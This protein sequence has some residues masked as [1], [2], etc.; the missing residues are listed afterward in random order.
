MNGKKKKQVPFQESLTIRSE[1]TEACSRVRDRRTEEAQQRPPHRRTGVV[2]A[3]QDFRI[4][5]PSRWTRIRTERLPASCPTL[6]LRDSVTSHHTHKATTHKEKNGQRSVSHL[7]VS[8]GRKVVSPSKPKFI[9][10]F[11]L[12]YRQEK[13]QCTTQ[14]GGGGGGRREGICCVCLLSISVVPLRRR[15]ELFVRFLFFVFFTLFCPAF[16]S[17]FVLFASQSDVACVCPSFFLV[18]SFSPQSPATFVYVSN[19]TKRK[20]KQKLW[21]CLCFLFVFV[22]FL[23][24]CCGSLCWLQSA[25]YLKENVIQ[26]RS[27]HSSFSI[28]NGRR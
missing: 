5:M 21:I 11:L 26:S 24:I 22:F 18:H 9:L 6:F 27:H 2:A 10:L 14:S 28:Q 17:S 1:R 3:G 16:L 13:T 4:L 12:L 20:H 23:P 15:K 25:L 7:F 8:L 19:V